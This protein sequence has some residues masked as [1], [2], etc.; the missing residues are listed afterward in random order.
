MK[1]ILNYTA[2]NVGTVEQAI[3]N[4]EH[5]MDQVQQ[6]QVCGH[7]RS[8]VIIFLL[9]TQ[10][11]INNVSHALVSLHSEVQ[12]FKYELKQFNNKVREIFHEMSNGRKPPRLV[13]PGKLQRI[14][15]PLRLHQKTMSIPL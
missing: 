15:Q 4:L 2:G 6:A 12:S 5:N 8:D 13:E 1:T 9:K 10:S 14:L 11:V 3:N 7:K